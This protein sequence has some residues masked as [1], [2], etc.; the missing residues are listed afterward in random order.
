MSDGA[1]AVAVGLLGDIDQPL[2]IV[3]GNCSLQGIDYK[4]E[5]PFWTVH[6]STLLRLFGRRIANII[7]ITS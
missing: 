7:I 4:G 2:A 3:G 6:M 1:N 5:D